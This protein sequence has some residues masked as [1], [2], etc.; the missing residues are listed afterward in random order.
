MGDGAVGARR[1]VL[2]DDDVWVRTG[3][4]S[5][6][7]MVPEVEVLADLGF[8]EALTWTSEWDLVDVAVV[9][10]YERRAGFDHF[11]G[12][13]VVASIRARRS[14]EETVVVVVSGRSDD[15]HLRLRM[16]EVGADFF[17]GTTRSTTRRC[18]PA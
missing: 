6:L 18:S 14:P 17:Y 15:C 3:Q 8:A 10:A 1:V 5:S 13:E 4:A 11:L 2:I 16:A 9:D 12:A 7:S